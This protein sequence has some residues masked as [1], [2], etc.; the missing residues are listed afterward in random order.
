MVQKIGILY[1]TQ[2]LIKRTHIV[3]MSVKQPWFTH[4]KTLCG[5]KQ[6]KIIKQ[7]DYTDSITE[8]F[9]HLNNP[10]SNICTDCLNTGNPNIVFLTKIVKPK[11]TT[12]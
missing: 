5:I 8:I 12:T 11:G 7:Y 9:T 2:K 3:D 4:Q 6:N 1:P 10:A